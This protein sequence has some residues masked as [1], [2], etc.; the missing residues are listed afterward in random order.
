MFGENEYVL[1]LT[2]HE[3]KNPDGTLFNEYVHPGKDAGL[4]S[5]A[6]GEQSS[7]RYSPCCLITHRPQELKFNVAF[8]SQGD[9]FAIY[10]DDTISR[11]N[12][13]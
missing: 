11:Q 2:Y 7:F 8:R 4:D 12:M 6:V 1:I 3:Q 13:Q 5:D 9:G 10:I